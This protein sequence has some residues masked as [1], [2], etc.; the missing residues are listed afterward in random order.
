MAVGQVGL[1][2]AT[3]LLYVPIPLAAVHQFG[4]LTL[5]TFLTALTHSLNFSKYSR[6]MGSAA[7]IAQ[8]IVK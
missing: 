1:G 6:A 7:I 3:L 2:I 8:K 4:S 5:L